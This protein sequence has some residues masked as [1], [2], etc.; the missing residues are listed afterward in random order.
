[1]TAIPAFIPSPQQADVVD[2]TR[3]GSGSLFLRAR[4][5]TGKTTTLVQMLKETEG[6]VAFAA[7]NRKI[8]DEIKAKCAPLGL[9]NRVRVGTFHSFG[10]NA[11][12]RAHPQVKSGPE[13]AREKAEMT[14]AKFREVK[15]PE[16]LD[17]FVLKLVSLA[18][19]RAL[20]LFGSIDDKSIWY[21]IVDH[22]DLAYEIENEELIDQG[23]DLAIRTIRWQQSISGKIID[24][25]DMIY[26]PLIAGTRFWQNDW[27]F[28]DEAQD[29][30]PARRALARRML[31]PSGRAAFVGDDRQAIYG[32]TGAD[33][34]AIEQIVSDFNCKE[35]PLTVT[36]RCPK[37]VVT[38]AQSIVP[39]IEAHEDA[40]QGVVSTVT[41]PDFD[42]QTVPT[43]TA[44][45]AVLC[46]NTKPLVK[47]AFDLI[48]R[49]V[50]CHVEG[51]EIGGSLLKLLD[52]YKSARSLQQLLR[53]LDAYAEREVA[54][55][56]SKGRETQAEALQDRVDCVKVIA[57]NCDTIECIR[58]KITSMFQ[59][60]ENEAKP[61]LTL[62]TV[63]R[64]K[65]R[66]WG[67]VFIL[68]RNTYMP[69]PWARQAW[70]QH[71]EANLI[72]VAYTR[73]KSELTMI[74]VTAG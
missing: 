74:D 26:A 33:S 21:D 22:F 4:A 55:L 6:S 10:L 35:L 7:Y 23:V 64:S 19:Q 53:L 37:D 62:C 9:G 14:K 12:S 56:M 25:D 44:D 61:T 17:S 52:R 72:Y 30:N 59:D 2:W 24:F 8:A 29:T 46:R 42:K 51:R 63:H 13:A 47:L 60:G 28:V 34:D 50:A 45:D 40:P 67:R 16:A 71:Q 43:L 5:G 1:M 38:L 3:D 11:W 65:G 49:G 58:S 54:R 15:A 20:G 70:Q 48:K 27:V 31:R 57:D 39:D 68:G 32:F 66:E 73:A 18:K 36:R 41:Y 69:S